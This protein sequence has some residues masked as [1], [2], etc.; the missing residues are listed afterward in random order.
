MSAKRV[1]GLREAVA[2]VAEEEGEAVSV[3]AAA[4]VVASVAVVGEA[5]AGH[6]RRCSVDLRPMEVGC[7]AQPTSIVLLR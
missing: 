1:P 7:I 2:G 6:S 4:E 3:E 5:D